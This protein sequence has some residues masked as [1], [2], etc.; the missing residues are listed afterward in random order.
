VPRSKNEWSC[1][2]TPNKPSEHGAQLKTQGYIYLYL[3]S[4]VGMD[5]GKTFNSFETVPSYDVKR[6]LTAE[7]NPYIGGQFK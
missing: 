6:S 4:G 7:G 2:S 1:T 3:K 5:L